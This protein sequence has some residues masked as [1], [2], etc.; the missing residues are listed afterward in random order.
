MSILVILA[1]LVVFGFQQDESDRMSASARTFQAYL[2]GGGW[3]FENWRIGVAYV[4]GHLTWIIVISLLTLAISAL[5]V[6]WS[7]PDPRRVAGAL[8][9]TSLLNSIFAMYLC[10][11]A[12]MISR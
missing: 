9:V 12:S 11:P 1:T 10:A 2:E 8:L 4:V 6:D 5:L 3:G 7:K